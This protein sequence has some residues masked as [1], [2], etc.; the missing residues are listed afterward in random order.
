MPLKSWEFLSTNVL[1]LHWNYRIIF[2]DLKQSRAQIAFL[3]PLH[4]FNYPEKG[5]ILNHFNL[6]WVTVTIISFM[7]ELKRFTD[8]LF[9]ALQYCSVSMGHTCRLVLEF[10][11]VTTWTIV[12]ASFR[13]LCSLKLLG[14]FISWG[15]H[16][17]V[18]QI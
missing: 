10:G 11:C 16:K 13:T 14:W 3:L 6:K 4:F 17:N 2:W 9:G 8:L 15:I 18:Y 12:I 5:K 7:D 1:D